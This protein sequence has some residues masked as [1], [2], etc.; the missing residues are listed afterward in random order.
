MLLP[1]EFE[2]TILQRGHS[3]RAG[4]VW[5]QE[6]DWGVEF[7]AHAAGAITSIETARQI[8]RLQAER[9]ALARRIAELSEPP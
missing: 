4:V 8:R 9:E 5:R 3:R 6:H 2:L 1:T 7:L